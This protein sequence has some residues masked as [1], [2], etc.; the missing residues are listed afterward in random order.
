MTFGSFEI[1]R[2]TNGHVSVYENGDL[3]DSFERPL[4]MFRA[5]VTVLGRVFGVWK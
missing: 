4:P 3:T 2:G 1:K 5:I